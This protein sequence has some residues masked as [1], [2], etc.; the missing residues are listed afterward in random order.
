[1]MSKPFSGVILLC[2]VLVA[3][4]V[5]AAETYTNAW[6]MRFVQIPAGD[7]MMG[8]KDREEALMQVPEPKKNELMD[9]LPRHRVTIRHPFYI[10]VT[11]VTQ[12]Q[13]LAIMENRPGPGALWQ[14]S[15]WEDLPVVSINW[16]MAQRLVEELNKLD[17]SVRYRLPT[18]AEWEYVA[19]DGHDS[20]RPVE[21]EKLVDYAWYIRNSGDQPHPVA[22]RQP[23]GYG[24]Y[25]MLG[26]A[27]EWVAD[28]YAEDAYANA[29]AED[30]QGP[31]QGVS[32]VRR[33]GSY[34]CPEHLV[35]PGYRAA[36]RPQVK[37]EVTGVRLVIEMPAD[38]K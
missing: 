5:M 26:N 38:G 23:N 19:R 15:D 18:E 17:N 8:L 11:E 21:L 31:E 36:N 6:G 35:R 37:Y 32:R 28:W 13:W 3:N 24:V 2:V 22:T 16:Y 33:G 27:W 30:P 1:M 12:K 4:N 20:L 34:H 10:G 29:E 9:E 14:R 7:F 25:D